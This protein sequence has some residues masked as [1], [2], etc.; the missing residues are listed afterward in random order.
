[1]TLLRTEDI[2]DISA[3]LKQY[4]RELVRKTGRTLRGIACHALSLEEEEFQSLASSVPV[5]VVPIRSGQGVISRFSPTVRDIVVHIGF[6]A[7]VT[8]AADVAGIAEAAEKGVEVIMIADDLRF[9][10]LC[11]KTGRIVDNAEA[12]AKGFV[13]GLDLMTGGID[14]QKVLVIGCGPV[15]RS[16][17]SA[18]LQR[19]AHMSVFDI[20]IRRSQNLAGDISELTG[21]TVTVE[22]SIDRRG[23]ACLGFDLMVEATNTADV[24]HEA[25][26]T[27]ET[28]IAAP[29]MPLGLTPAAIREVSDRLLHDPLQ[30]GVSVM[31]IEAAKRF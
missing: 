30:L 6:N 25:D 3:Q 11:L 19:G 8:Q 7:F 18:A 24:I 28:Y 4:D 2:K 23:T 12:T 10:A 27:S 9:I 22:E 29:G 15:G 16:A 17:V 21:K 31:A 13:A 20:D 1:M 26:I 14:Q 5:A